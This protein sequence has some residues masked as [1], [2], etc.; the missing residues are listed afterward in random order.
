MGAKINIALLQI[1]P[2][3]SME[4]NKEKGIGYCKEAKTLGADIALFPEMWSSGYS[5]P[6]DA[7][8]LNELAISPDSEFVLSWQ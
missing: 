5:I 8:R 6:H 1:L 7:E 2:G 4:E 3:K